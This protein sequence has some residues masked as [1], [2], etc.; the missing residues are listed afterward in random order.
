MNQIEIFGETTF[1][2]VSQVANKTLV[3]LGITDADLEI[4]FIDESSIQ[5]LNFKYRKIDKPTDVLSFPQIK[6][7][8]TERT[9]LGNIV[10]CE[11]IV[12][13]KNENIIDVTKHGILH[14]VGYDHEENETE[15]NKKAEEIGCGL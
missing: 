11:K 7:P 5:K 15:W 10:I 1:S 14:L 6:I 12:R 13:E 8:G 2:N 4:S 3:L 9:A